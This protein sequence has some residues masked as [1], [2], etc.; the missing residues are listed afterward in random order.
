VR[1][2]AGTYNG[3]IALMLFNLDENNA[4]TVP[5]TID[6]K[7][8]GSGTVWTYDKAIYDK[9]QKNVWAAPIESKLPAWSKG[10]SVNLPPWSMVVVRTQ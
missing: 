2:Y 7:T 3:G 9:S 1:A 6:K 5:V 10:F 8:S 4:A